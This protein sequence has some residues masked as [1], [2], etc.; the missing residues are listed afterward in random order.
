MSP[1]CVPLR[2][3]VTTWQRIKFS[4]WSGVSGSYLLNSVSLAFNP[5][6]PTPNPHPNLSFDLSALYLVTLA[7]S[8]LKAFLAQARGGAIRIMK[9]VIRNGKHDLFDSDTLKLWLLGAEERKANAHFF[10]LVCRGV[11]ARLLQ[12]AST[13]LGQG[14][15]S[16]PA[17]SAHTSGTLLHPLPSGLAERSGIRVDLHRLVTWPLTSTTRADTLWLIRFHDWN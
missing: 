13:E 12:R 17:S 10:F 3:G 7:T 16:V 4:P 6:P 5:Q 8:E 9:I 15:R 1:T 11:G 2:D 14:L